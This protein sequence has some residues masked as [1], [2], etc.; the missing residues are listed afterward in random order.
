MD[1]RFQFT[2]IVLVSCFADQKKLAA[3]CTILLD[4]LYVE[5]VFYDEQGLG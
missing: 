1:H 3:T 5:S 4:R 2:S